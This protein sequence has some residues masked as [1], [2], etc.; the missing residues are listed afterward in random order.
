MAPKIINTE[1]INGPATDFTSLYPSIL[2][3]P[4]GEYYDVKSLVFGNLDNGFP[5][6]TFGGVN[7]IDC[8]GPS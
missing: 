1:G 7:P 6:S 3:Q 4:N 5:D 2:V 8:G